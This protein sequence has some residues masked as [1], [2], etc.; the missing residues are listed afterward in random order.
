MSI[1]SKKTFV[2]KVVSEKMD[3]TITVLVSMRRLDP[4]YKKFIT[5]TK[6]YHVHDQENDAHI[7]DVV[8]IVESRPISKSKKWRLL[9][10]V[11]RVR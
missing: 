2:G 5:R 11:E 1:A 10:I 7:G 4:L 8:R 9:E 6:K 3:K